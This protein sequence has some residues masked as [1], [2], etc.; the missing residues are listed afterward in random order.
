M[1]SERFGH[2]PAN[3][4][5][6]RAKLSKE[7]IFGRRSYSLVAEFVRGFR[8]LGVRPTPG[9]ESGAGYQMFCSLAGPPRNLATAGEYSFLVMLSIG[10]SK[11]CPAAGNGSGSSKVTA[12]ARYTVGKRQGSG[13][14]L[15][16]NGCYNSP[17][18]LGEEK[19]PRGWECNFKS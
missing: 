11:R 19:E 8:V 17:T 3:S 1:G 16:S 10:Y 15:R 18:G 5:K 13:D 4:V 2:N 12:Y 9:G 7:F 14:N 6:S